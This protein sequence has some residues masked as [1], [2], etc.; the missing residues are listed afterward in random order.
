MLYE[1]PNATLLTRWLAQMIWLT[2]V[3]VVFC[4]NFKMY[5]ERAAIIPFETCRQSIAKYL[6]PTNSAL[7]WLSPSPSMREAKLC[8]F[9]YCPTHSMVICNWHVLRR[10]INPSSPWVC[11]VLL[12]QVPDEISCDLVPETNSETLPCMNSLFYLCVARS[13]R[14]GSA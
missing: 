8:L 3:P 7:C 9:R 4:T 2:W 11:R 12:L 13:S 10:A 1:A 5:P 14:Y 6:C